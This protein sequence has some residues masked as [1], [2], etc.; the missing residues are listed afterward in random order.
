YKFRPWIELGYFISGILL[1]FIAAYGAQQIILLKR[2]IETRN[3]RASRELTADCCARFADFVLMRRKFVRECD[4][5]GLPL[6]A[7]QP[8]DFSTESLLEAEHTVRVAQKLKLDSVI[9]GLNQ[10]ELIAMVIL[11]GAADDQLAF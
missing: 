3:L 9:A 7:G 8:G 1:I 5:A 10:L 2:D 6:Y 4:E 11:S